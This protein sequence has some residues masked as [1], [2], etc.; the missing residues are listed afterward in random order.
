MQN[1]NKAEI[2]NSILTKDILSIT[3]I[4]SEQTET[5]NNQSELNKTFSTLVNVMRKATRII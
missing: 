5:S 3:N 1:V 4:L 2:E